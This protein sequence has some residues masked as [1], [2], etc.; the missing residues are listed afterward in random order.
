ME[1][2]RRSTRKSVRAEESRYWD[3]I[4]KNVKGQGA[5]GIT[6]NIWK[7]CE[8][9]S[10][11][12][13]H[14]PVNAKVLEIGAGQGLTPAVISRALLGN[15]KY[16]GTDVS[17]EFCRFVIGRWG[18]SMVQT[19]ILKLPDGP[20]DQI[21]AF[22]SLEHVRPEERPA[23]YAEMSRVLGPNGKIFLNVPLNE[24][25]H[26]AEFDWGMNEREVFDIAEATGT[27][28]QVYEPY[29]IH[30]I[31]RSY[32]WAELVRVEA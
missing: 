1:N 9:I 26:V 4:A 23:G 29:D 15:F 12:L 20:F 10:R 17:E 30:E 2:W 16:L 21:W 8:I 6:D 11:I 7:R 25:G 31:E 5:G 28:V 13:K 18:L 27:H 32:L 3:H 24:S 19:D 14:R 22:D